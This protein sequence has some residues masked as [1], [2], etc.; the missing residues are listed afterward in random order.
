MR[1]MCFIFNFEYISSWHTLLNIIY[2]YMADKYK[3]NYHQESTVM[4]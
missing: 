2:S 1:Q 3:H 4:S